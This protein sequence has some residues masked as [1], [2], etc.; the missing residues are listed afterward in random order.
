LSLLV[1]ASGQY[2]FSQLLASEEFGL[3]G[4]RF[5]RAYNPSE[6]TGD[7][8][9]GAALELRFSQSLSDDF[10]RGLQ[11]YGF[12]DYG[13]VWRIDDAAADRRLSLA[14]AGGGVRFNLLDDVSGSVELAWPLTATPA[15][16]DGRGPRLFF[17][18]VRRF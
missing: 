14:S 9:L 12:T 4:G 3:G 5:G 10:L 7:H 2:A 17:T 8:G 15:A 11:V 13:A 18:F 6:V 16:D 1:E